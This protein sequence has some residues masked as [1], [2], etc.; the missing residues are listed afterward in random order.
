MGNVW[1]GW[2]WKVEIPQYMW[3]K[4]KHNERVAL[5]VGGLSLPLYGSVLASFIQ[6][7]R[8]FTVCQ[9]AGPG[10]RAVKRQSRSSALTV[11]ESNAQSNMQVNKPL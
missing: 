5:N 9:A 6:I 8:A 11:G 10:E 3:V 1:D 7:F 4:V 2:G